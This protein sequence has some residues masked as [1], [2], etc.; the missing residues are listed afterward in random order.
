VAARL[1]FELAT[2]AQG[3]TGQLRH[4]DDTIATLEP[5]DFRRPTRLGDW[6]VAQLIAH[7][8]GSSMG[9]LLTEPSALTPECDVIDWALA[10]APAAADVNERAQGLAE[11]SRPAEM[12]A[13]FRE[14]RVDV[15]RALASLDSTF[16]VPARWGAIRLT[17]YLATRCVELTVHSLD[18]AAALDRQVPVDADATAVATRLLAAALSTTAPGRSVELRVPPHVAVQVVEGPRHTRGTPPNVVEM[19]PLTWLEL[20]TGRCS[21]TD[22]VSAGRVVASGER[23]DLSAYLPVLS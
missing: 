22:A 9:T 12:R 6:Q 5:E 17:D 23:A 1:R 3:V 13:M 15:G 20:A 11:E 21:W 4:L 18:L 14:M 8:G 19:D 7:L 16:I 2:V 10:C